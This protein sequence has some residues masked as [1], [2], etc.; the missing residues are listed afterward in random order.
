MSTTPIIPGIEDDL[1]RQHTFVVEQRIHEEAFSLVVPEAF[2]QSI[3]DLGYKSTYTAIDELVDNAVQANA[4]MV[5]VFLAYGSGNKSKAKPDYVIVADN[6]HGMEPDMIRL[7]VK[8][9][10]TH[11]HDDRNGFGRYGFGLPSACVS[12]GRAYTVY[13]KTPDG[14]WHAV[15]VDID[16]VASAAVG[17]ERYHVVVR[18]KTPP[19]YVTAHLD[20]TSF[21]S[22][23]IIVIETLDRLS[24]GFKTTRSF[25]NN[26]KEHVGV[27]YRKLMPQID[28]KVGGDR[29]LPVDPLF[30]DPNARWYEETVIMAE[31]VESIE[32]ELV[33]KEG[34]TGVV[35]IR[36][37]AFPYNFH[38]KAP[39][40]PL[41][42]SNHNA[43]YAIMKDLNGILVCRAGRQ[44]DCVTRLPWT[45]FVN[46]D[47]FFAIEIDFDPV[48]DEYFGITT[49]KQQVVFSESMLGHLENK[50]L[51]D[52]IKDLRAAMKKSRSQVK[53]ALEN[54][55]KKRASEEAM[56]EAQR[57]KPRSATSSPQKK[58]RAEEQLDHEARK[59]S[60]I[61]GEPVEQAKERIVEQTVQEPYK[62][63]FEG[64]PDGPVFRGERMGG[65]YRLVINTRHRFYDDV[66]EPARQVAGLCSKLEA[67]MFVIAEA[68]LDAESEQESFYKAG[69]I[70]LSQRFTD[71][72]AVLD[73]SGESEDEKSAEMEEEEV[74]P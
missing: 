22:G 25:V 18:K 44:I 49:H 11:R 62:V 30:L 54:R 16:E 61:T 20:V 39:D 32:F 5:D 41:N 53:T 13:S 67:A 66:Y 31:S 38:L 65:Q 72:L 24:S 7:A 6:G 42:S 73:G 64:I 34:Q 71:V 35:R 10:G 15:R 14:D 23:T 58:K 50:G 43:R 59:Q 2:V 28:I 27:I 69:R 29:V 45:T 40:G 9:G 21:V 19:R 12:I 55:E 48:L 60:D 51:K 68:E 3:R 1:Q 4:N 56:K 26:M 57:R 46:F 74:N 36:G 33:G 63:A 52:L 8:W 70:F 47:R 37:A 17:Q